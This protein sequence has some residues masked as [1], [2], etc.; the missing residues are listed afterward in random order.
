MDT[1]FAW[2]D[3]ELVDAVNGERLQTFAVGDGDVP[4]V[5]IGGPEAIWLPRMYPQL[6]DVTVYAGR[7]GSQR[8]ARRA[9]RRTR[10]ARR[11]PGGPR[12]ARWWA[13]RP[14]TVEGPTA[15]SRE[16]LGTTVVAVAHD[17]EGNPVQT[18]TL[19]GVD[20]YTFT[21]ATLSWAAVRARGDRMRGDGALGPVAAFGL[22]GLR[23]ACAGLASAFYSLG[24][25]AAE[26]ASEPDAERLLPSE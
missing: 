7:A 21:A 5:A 11:L 17:G 6:R 3:G 23:E 12:T 16:R 2:R 4:A 9:A 22:A 10:T 15:E 19:Q 18:V 14:A 25:T 13:A 8:A 24:E 1:H 26:R 20:P